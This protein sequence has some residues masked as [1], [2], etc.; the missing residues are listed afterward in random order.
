MVIPEGRFSSHS[1]ALSLATCICGNCAVSVLHDIALLHRYLPFV[2]FS[3][4][5]RGFEC[6]PRRDTKRES[7][8]IVKVGNVNISPRTAMSSGGGGMFV[9]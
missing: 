4:F 2:Y 1:L 5:I 9:V 8:Q 3:S 6:A 7:E